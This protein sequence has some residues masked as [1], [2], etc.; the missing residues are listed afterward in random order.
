LN[1]PRARGKNKWLVLVA[2]LTLNTMGRN[3]LPNL[4]VR[5]VRGKLS[6]ITIFAKFKMCCFESQ[7]SFKKIPIVSPP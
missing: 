7:T 5:C 1:G 6:R 4:E 2:L 3:F